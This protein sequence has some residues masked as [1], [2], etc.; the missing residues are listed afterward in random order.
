MYKK[1]DNLNYLNIYLFNAKITVARKIIGLFP[2][3]KEIQ[4]LDSSI[5]NLRKGLYT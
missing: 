2:S 1:I 3:H 4:K 5:Q